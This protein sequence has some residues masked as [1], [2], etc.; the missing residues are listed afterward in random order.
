MKNY[1][2]ILSVIIAGLVGVNYASIK[3]VNIDNNA[4]LV[5]RN[6]LRQSAADN[7]GNEINV[8]DV[9]IVS[10]RLWENSPE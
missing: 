7:S 3:N 1:I 10:Q 9:S 5:V 6:V 2:K 8:A 4:G